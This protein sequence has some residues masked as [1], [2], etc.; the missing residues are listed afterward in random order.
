MTAREIKAR[1]TALRTRRAELEQALAAGVGRS[2]R[3]ELAEVQEEL[4][5]C[6]RQLRAQMPRH[7][8]SYRRVSWEQ[9][10]GRR[11]DAL[12]GKD[13]TDL[14]EDRQES[15]REQMQRAMGRAM[16][17]AMTP[18]QARYMGRQ[19]AGSRGADIA[20]DS[21]RTRSTVSR[22]LSRGRGRLEQWAKA[23]YAILQA[24]GR[25]GETDHPVIDFGDP[26][27]LRAV[28]AMLT[29]RQQLYLYLYYGEWLSLREISALIGLAHHTPVLRSI[30]A[31][32]E[33]IQAL[34]MGGPVE[35][36]GWDSLEERLMEHYNAL[37]LETLDLAVHPRPAKDVPDV[38]V[39]QQTSH[40]PA[41]A[42]PAVPQVYLVRGGQVRLGTLRSAGR[43][44][45]GRLLAAL[46]ARLASMSRDEP[47]ETGRHWLQQAARRVLYRLF[48][49]LRGGLC[50][51]K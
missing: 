31:A 6:A 27:V 33:R 35:L 39:S 26:E 8:V 13:W 2:V 51:E 15:E 43:W 5:D 24:Q 3:L 41:S 38:P 44:G 28:L 48:E 49:L 34:A 1:A 11:W 18:T 14:E 29:Q 21:A 12:E 16:E 40:Q 45:S 19:L 47:S 4:A 36:R 46:R 50:G 10:E 42:P 37:D 7:R 23:S 22:T 17:S 30:Q 20:R 25:A 32:L 9:V